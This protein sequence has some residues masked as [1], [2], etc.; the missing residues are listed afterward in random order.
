MSLTIRVRALAAVMAGA[1]MMLGSVYL[2]SVWGAE[3]AGPGANESTFVPITPVRVMDTRDPTNLGLAGPFVSPAPLDLK[4]TGNVP[5]SGGTKIVVPSGASAVT[6][7]LTVVAAQA[8]GFVSVRPANATGNVQTSSLN[9]EA[10]KVVANSVT[11]SLPVSAGAD[12]GKLEITYVASGS[13]GAIA[14]LLV[15]VAG[16]YLNGGL[17]ELIPYGDILMSYDHTGLVGISGAPPTHTLAYTQAYDGDVALPL[18]GPISFTGQ[19]YH[20]TSITICLGGD[21]N[22]GA[23]LGAVVRAGPPA[24]S[25]VSAAG[26]LSAQGCHTSV[27]TGSPSGAAGYQLWLVIDGTV[28]LTGFQATWSPVAP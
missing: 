27:I 18:A 2:F 6:I 17:Q 21:P 13:P 19:Q 5:T 15:D 24:N 16:Y 26:L 12:S 3:A 1:A 25:S 9:F 8:N 22:L 7:N 11:V 10:G 14:N 20:V 28:N 4:V 23:V